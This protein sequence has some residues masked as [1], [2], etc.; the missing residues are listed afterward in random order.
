MFTNLTD[1]EEARARPPAPEF[2]ADAPW[3]NM[4]APLTLASLR[5]RVVLLHFW[6]WSNIHC[7]H[8]LADLKYLENK[9]RDELAIIGVHAPKF[10]HERNP[11]NVVRACNRHY[12]RHPVVGD[13]SFAIWQAHGVPAW[14]TYVAIDVA[15]RVAA[16]LSGEGRRAELDALVAKLAA[17]A[18]PH[19]T[20]PPLTT[21]AR[22]EPKTALRFPGKVAATA[23][24]LYVSD[25]GHNRVLEC[26]HEGRVLRQFGAG[27]SGYW[28]GRGTDCGYSEPQ[29]L[30]LG[31]NALYVA[32]RGNHSVRRIT[33]A[34]GETTTV[35]GTGVHGRWRGEAGDPRSVPLASPWD[36]VV[37]GDQLYVALAGQHQ[38]G[39]LD[40]GKT[41]W[42]VFGGN[43]REALVDGALADASFAK[44]LGLA[45]HAQ[46]I[47]VACADA[48]ALRAIKLFDRSVRTV[49]G[50]GLHEHGD[51]VGDAGA[52][53][54]QHPSAVALEPV[55]AELWIADAFN[56]KLKAM[57]LRGGASRVVA[58][59]HRFHEPGGLAVTGGVAFVANTN[60]H[61]ILKVD[62]RDGRVARVPVAE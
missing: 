34:S 51:A 25:T 29:G 20:P 48:S 56:G 1:D 53:R 58:P 11:A 41:R 45:L 35:A 27:Q 14:P 37:A 4:R 3:I 61:E 42:S 30:A 57:S 10:E 26:T 23:D 6:T 38:I 46:T 62:L 21:A 2:P 13:P 55:A 24:R 15:G 7:I 60:A 19:E 36:L 8:A 50:T 16:K 31:P 33:L 44:P 39:V 43:G 47:Y 17:E 18:E 40:L 32:D 59:E 28:D 52:L 49:A 5:G 54:L 22:P 9:Y 12:V